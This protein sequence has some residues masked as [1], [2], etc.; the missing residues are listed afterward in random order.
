MVWDGD[1]FSDLSQFKDPNTVWCLPA[2]CKTQK[3]N[4]VSTGK[5]IESLRQLLTA[6]GLKEISYQKCHEKF[7]TYWRYFNIFFYNGYKID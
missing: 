2:K 7:F 3:C 5:A 1:R 4:N 6:E